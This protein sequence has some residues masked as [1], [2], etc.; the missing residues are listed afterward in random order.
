MLDQPPSDLRLLDL[1]PL[2]LIIS[3]IKTLE[4][5]QRDLAKRARVS[6]PA[7]SKMLRESD[8]ESGTRYSTVRA[9]CQ[10]IA[11]MLQERR[12]QPIGDICSKNL[13]GVQEDDSVRRALGKMR[14]KWFSQLAVFRGKELLGT[15]GQA[16]LLGAL[17]SGVP[18]PELMKG[19]VGDVMRRTLPIVEE[20]EPVAVVQ[21]LL[22]YNS[23]VLVRIGGK[24]R[25]I[26][27]W[28][29]ILGPKRER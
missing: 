27:T 3:T 29:D 12:S 16:D 8:R 25:G 5:S 22:M 21:L 20:T 23:G 17:N 1:P 4:L 19:R 14:G 7:I 24:V 11:G 6:Q 13:V 10:A 28:A 9:V 26:A 18:F 15:V 2:E